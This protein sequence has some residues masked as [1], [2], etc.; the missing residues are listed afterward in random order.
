MDLLPFSIRLGVG[1]LIAAGAAWWLGRREQVCP[2]QGDCQGA[3]CLARFLALALLLALPPTGLLTWPWPMPEALSAL[4]ALA[5]FLHA[6]TPRPAW[7][8][9]AHGAAVAILLT[10]LVWRVGVRPP[11]PDGTAIILAGAVTA[12]LL[13]ARPWLM[14]ERVGVQIATWAAVCAAMIGVVVAHAQ[15]TLSLIAVVYA[16]TCGTA[17]LVAAWRGAG[18]L[19]PAASLLPALGAGLLA[20]T[21]W[22]SY[23][24]DP[25]EAAWMP[26]ARLAGLILLAL[27]PWSVALL[28]RFGRPR[29]GLALGVLIGLA[30][31]AVPLWAY[32]FP[33]QAPPPADTGGSYYDYYRT[34]GQP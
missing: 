22:G 18:A 20:V 12:A 17:L 7:L 29:W 10:C 5:V 32:R 34:L 9:A 24:Q 19:I 6:W 21:A 26:W 8:Q 11:L 2:V 25:K 27:I 30:A 33:Q 14:K 4:L 16:A 3:G 1:V 15:V 13:A 23:A 31:I 28:A